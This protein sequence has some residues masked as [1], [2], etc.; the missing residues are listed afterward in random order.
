MTTEF[1][2]LTDEELMCL[3]QKGNLKP[4]SELARRYE[5]RLLGFLHRFVGNAA[6]AEDLLQ[7]TLLR[8]YRARDKFKGNGK[9]STWLYTIAA[10]LAKDY[11]RKTKKYRFVSLETPVGQRVNVID[12]H[13]AEGE[14]AYDVAQKREI[15]KMVRLAVSRLP[16]HLRLTVLLTHYEQMSYEEAAKVLGCSKGTVKSRVFRA[17]MKLKE[18]L[19]DYTAGKEVARSDE[20]QEG[21]Q[22]VTGISG[23]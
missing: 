19:A 15:S 16:H 20:L 6:Q 8:V 2:A 1:E 13:E 5:Q 23:S 17:K 7:A 22:A 18:F 12:F 9:F 10:N 4:F 14:S 21:D 11:L 3:V